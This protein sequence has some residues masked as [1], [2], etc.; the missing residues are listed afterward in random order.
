MFENN[1]VLY[2]M[3]MMIVILSYLIRYLKVLSQRKGYSISMM[4]YLRLFI[5]RIQSTPAA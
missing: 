2:I 4:R 1:F 3:I 5:L